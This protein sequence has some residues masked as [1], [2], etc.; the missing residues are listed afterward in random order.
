MLRSLKL[1]LFVLL[2]TALPAFGQIPVLNSKPGAAYNLYLDY[3][4]FTFTG[5]WG[6]SFTTLTPTPASAYTGS[7]ADMTEIWTRTAEKYSAF[8]VNVTTVDPAPAGTFASRQLF[9][10]QQAQFM[11]TVVGDTSVDWA[12]G[13]SPGISFVG[14][15]QNAFTGGNNSQNGGAGRGVHTNWVFSNLY[16]N[17]PKLIAEGSSHENGHGLNLNHQNQYSTA[18]VYQAEYDR[19]TG[20][21]FNPGAAGTVS[22]IMGDSYY[23]ERGLWR[24]GQTRSPTTF[25]VSPQNDIQALLGNR[26][27]NTFVDSGIGHTRPTATALPLTGNT[28]NS[29]SAKGVITPASTVAP[30]PIG[31][32]NYT[33]DV[34]SFVVAGGQ[35]ANLNVSLRSGR[36]TIT[37]GTAD[38]GQVLN[39]TLRLLDV[40]GNILVTANTGTFLETITQNNLAAGTYYL[41]IASAGGVT[42]DSG[43]PNQTTYFDM[44]SYFLTGTLTPVPEPVTVLAVAVLGLGLVRTGRRHWANLAA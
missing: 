8:N 7:T 40:S 33:K 9:Y 36:S 6:G 37:A 12:G 3:G 16:D 39:A 35:T 22:P 29:S 41:E 15:T 24:V 43:L 26:N 11:H 19:A 4:G 14:V 38:P 34:F 1:S 21:P 42:L 27:L 23:A 10:D 17:N 31:E 20:D 13:G 5:T 25:V 30:N 44:G 18:G 28:I 32:A 2:C